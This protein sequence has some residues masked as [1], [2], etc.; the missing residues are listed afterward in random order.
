MVAHTLTLAAAMRES[1]KA[2]V[3]TIPA[4]KKRLDVRHDDIEY[5]EVI[6]QRCILHLADGDLDISTNIN[7]DDLETM[8]PKPRFYRTHR[9]Y[10]VNMDRVR[11]SNGTDFVMQN[12]GIAYITQKDYRR[13]MDAYDNWLLGQVTE[14]GP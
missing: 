6:N 13:V 1:Q 10:I 3:L 8:L 4:A 2:N 12:G 9:S 5:A 14:D 11:R 7:I